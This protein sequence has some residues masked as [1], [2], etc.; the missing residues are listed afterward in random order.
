MNEIVTKQIGF[1]FESNNNIPFESRIEALKI[2]QAKNG[3]MRVYKDKDKSLY[4]FIKNVRQTVK[5]MEEGR[6]NDMKITPDW[7]EM[8]QQIGFEFEVRS[9][10]SFE[11]CIEDVKLYQGKHGYMHVLE[12]GK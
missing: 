1:K 3:H 10:V 5:M 7:I 8:L 11:S 2:Y 12:G 6:T 4:G 9:W